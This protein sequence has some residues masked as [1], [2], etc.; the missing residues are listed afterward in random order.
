MSIVY[1]KSICIRH[2]PDSTLRPQLL[3]WLKFF[4][5]FLFSCRIIPRS[6]LKRDHVASN[7]SLA[8]LQL[9]ISCYKPETFPITLQ[10]RWDLNCHYCRGQKRFTFI[11][12]LNA[13]N[14]F[15]PIDTCPHWLWGPT[16]LLYNRH[17][18]V[19]RAGHGVD[20][21]PSSSPTCRLGR[22]VPLTTLCAFMACYT[23]NITFTVNATTTVLCNVVGSM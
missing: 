17:P 5:V 18:W 14:R 3:F 11:T 21:P 6:C 16:I 22:A 4:V 10:K 19:K 1:R 8:I 13:P 12:P 2:A 7:S 9:S 20:H 15:S 23:E